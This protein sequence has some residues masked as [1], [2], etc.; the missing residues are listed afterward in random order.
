MLHCRNGALLV[1]AYILCVLGKGLDLIYF[2]LEYAVRVRALAMLHCRNGA[3]LVPAYILCVLREG[4]DLNLF[5]AGIC[6]AVR[7]LAML[8]RRN[9]ALLVPAYILLKIEFPQAVPEAEHPNAKRLGWV[10]SSVETKHNAHVYT[11]RQAV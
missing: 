3:L 9:G 1:P 8:H 2:R 7:A 10:D 11:E 4:L 6:G 5:W